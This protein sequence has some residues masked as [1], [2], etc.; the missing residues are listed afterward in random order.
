MGWKSKRRRRGRGVKWFRKAKMQRMRI[1]NSWCRRNM[2]WEDD[3][4]ED[5]KDVDEKRAV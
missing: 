5:D 1:E 4:K 2:I 3:G